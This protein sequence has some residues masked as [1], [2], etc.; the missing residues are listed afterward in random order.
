[1]AENVPP[2]PVPKNPESHVPIVPKIC[3]VSG[4]PLNLNGS[5]GKN[6]PTIMATRTQLKNFRVC[7]A[8][9]SSIFVTVKRP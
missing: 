8:E 1:M 6:T 4:E 3:C 9:R 7:E 5:E 2:I